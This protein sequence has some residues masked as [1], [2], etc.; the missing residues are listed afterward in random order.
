MTE[1]KLLLSIRTEQHVPGDKPEV[2][3]LQ[4]EGTLRRFEDRV[5]IS[6]METEMT[7]LEGVTT[8]FTLYPDQRMVLTRDGEKLK[9]QMIFQAGARNDSLYDV[10]FGAL[11]ISTHTQSVEADLDAGRF[12]VEYTVEVEH[13]FMGTNSYLVTFQYLN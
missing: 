1:Q 5:E 9:N 8:T 13:T 7:G 10:G 4:S 3:V 11:L 12:R 2:M 6:Y